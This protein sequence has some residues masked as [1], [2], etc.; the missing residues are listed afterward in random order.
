[1]PVT[2]TTFGFSTD[3]PLTGDW[4]GDGRMDIGVFRPSTHQFIF[5]TMPVTRTTFGLGTDIPITGKWE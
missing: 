3:I 1:M 5:N 4:N 2:R